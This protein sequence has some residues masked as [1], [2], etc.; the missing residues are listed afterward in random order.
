MTRDQR[1]EELLRDL[2]ELE[3]TISDAIRGRHA[4]HEDLERLWRIRAHLDEPQGEP[5]YVWRVTR[6]ESGWVAHVAL[7]GKTA[8]DCYSDLPA[9]RIERAQIG[10]WETPARAPESGRRRNPYNVVESAG[11]A[12]SYDH[13]VATLDGW[14]HAE[15]Y[16]ANCRQIWPHLTFDVV[17]V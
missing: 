8:A 14:D 6:I 16:A 3:Q 2:D 9:Y 1:A 17:A 13:I 12:S 5:E 10:P 4:D 11:R 15:Q 7:D